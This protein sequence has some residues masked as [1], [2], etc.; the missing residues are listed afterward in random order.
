MAQ[1]NALGVVTRF[2]YCDCGVLEAATNAWRSSVQFVTL[3][4]YDYQGRLLE[5]T[6]PDATL[7]NAYNV[8][9]QVVQAGDG[10][11]A[12]GFTYNQ[13]GGRIGATDPNGIVQTIVYDV[14]DRPLRVTD[15]PSPIRSPHLSP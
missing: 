2:G 1:T 14:E 10:W 5:T 9:S 15:V 4:T 8:L 13:Q 7:T 3:Y 11:T 12:Q 6:L